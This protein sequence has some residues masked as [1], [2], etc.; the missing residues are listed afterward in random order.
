MLKFKR[1]VIKISGEVLGGASGFGIDMDV[2]AFVV[3]EVL[4]AYELGAEVSIV[5]G[6]GNFI[7]GSKVAVKGIERVNSD[8]LGMISTILNS[9]TLSDTFTS[10]GVSSIV[11][12]AIPVDGIAEKYSVEK[13]LEYLSKRYILLLAGGTGNPF[14]STDTSA[15]LRAAELQADVVL[16]A[17]KVDGIYDK[18]PMKYPDA[19]KFEEID[20]NEVLLRNLKV[21]DLTAFSLSCES[22]IPIVVF[23]L[24]EKDVIRKI[25]SGEKV[26]TFVR[27]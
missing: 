5:V 6:G 27:V 12:S 11:L 7:R 17:T 21:M 10:R 13:A 14:F 18:D 22:K 8:R 19:K 4:K 15:V 16:K 26:G 23:N 24:M 2:V 20:G 1:C 9:I 25:V 3:D